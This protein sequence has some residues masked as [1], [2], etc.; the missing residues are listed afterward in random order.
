MC[1]LLLKKGDLK[2]IPWLLH[3]YNPPLL[4]APYGDLLEELSYSTEINA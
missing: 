3:G 1:K 4:E 2:K